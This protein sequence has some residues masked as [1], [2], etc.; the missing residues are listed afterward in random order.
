MPD[1]SD[2]P[3]TPPSPERSGVGGAMLSW[4]IVPPYVVSAA[5]TDRQ[6]ILVTF[7]EGMYGNDLSDA[8]TWALMALDGGSSASILFAVV[9]P[10]HMYVTLLTDNMSELKNYRVTAPASVVDSAGNYI[11]TREAD[12]LVPDVT[13]PN[14]VSATTSEGTLVH[15]DFSEALYGVD[16]EDH[17]QW[18]VTAQ[19]GGTPITIASV[20]ADVS[21][22]WVTLVVS[23][24][25]S[26]KTYRV[27]APATLR[28]AADN[29]I[30]GRTADFLV[31]D[32]TPPE[33]LSAS[34]TAL[35]IGLSAVTV[36]FSEDMSLVGLDTKENYSL[37]PLDPESAAPGVVLGVTVFSASSVLLLIQPTTNGQMY[38][39]AATNLTDVAGNPLVDTIDL[40][41]AGWRPR[42]V[43][44]ERLSAS[45]VMLTFDSLLLSEE[46]LSSPSSYPV[47]HPHPGGDSIVVEVTPSV[48]EPVTSV[49]LRVDPEFS[50]LEAY[51]VSAVG[52]RDEYFNT[53]DPAFCSFSSTG[54]GSAMSVR[55]HYFAERAVV[56]VADVDL[57]TFFVSSER[58]NFTAPRDLTDEVSDIVV[59]N[60]DRQIGVLLDAWVPLGPHTHP[61]SDVTSPVP[62]ATDVD[63]IAGSVHAADLMTSMQGGLADNAVQP[64]DL[65]DAVGAA[66]ALDLDK[67]VLGND[68]SQVKVGP[69][70]GSSGGV[71]DADKLAVLS[72]VGLLTP[73]MTR[74]RARIVIYPVGAYTWDNRA[75]NVWV[76]GHLIG[77]GGGGGSGRTY[78]AG[79]TRGGGGGGCGGAYTHFR[80]PAACLGAQAAVVVGAGGTGGARAEVDSGNNGVAGNPTSFTPVAFPSGYVAPGGDYG[81]GGGSSGG[82]GGSP[83]TAGQWAAAQGGAGGTSASAND[84]ANSS[85]GSSPYSGAGGG[86]GG[87]ISSSN[88]INLGGA[89]G[90][91]CA[92]SSPRPS[93]GS[94]GSIGGGSGAAGGSA[95]VNSCVAG[96]GGGGGSAPGG[97]GGNGGL[98]GGG[99][100]GGAAAVFPHLSGRGGD[101]GDGL[102]V[103]IS[104]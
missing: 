32:L 12:F 82:A 46:V 90:M 91:G 18:D 56:Q 48:G 55:G 25:Q 51:T 14:V 20:L 85:A 86:G 69:G 89:G 7:S 50:A 8:S 80:V 33:F 63:T 4:D 3:F 38:T 45:T 54:T 19:D 75:G 53:I 52:P 78:N 100:G 44:G 64:A 2:V 71:A 76:E 43:L 30:L 99:G 9:D 88:T 57:T 42:V 59:R 94:R 41:G 17:T 79:T 73:E 16:L 74:A 21:H 36:T 81:N 60:Q 101:G 11:T 77:G 96:G 28:D 23:G 95:V 104:W 49:T 72:A 47:T 24:G 102:A 10:T 92:A 5:A 98:Y 37:T 97:S 1:L 103:I 68:G 61:P 93:G 87:G 65:A 39:L 66:A 62:E 35:V 84:G 40:G 13:R 29:L 58:L 34:A 67:A 31:P 15:V 27:T 22:T 70:L 6:H 26:L 83:V